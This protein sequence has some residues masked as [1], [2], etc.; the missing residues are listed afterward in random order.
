MNYI[1]PLYP[2][3][4]GCIILMFTTSFA[5]I[6]VISGSIQLVLFGTIVLYPIW[7]TETLSYVDI[8]WPWGL[9]CIGLV[10]LFLGEGYSWRV[11][12]IG[13]LYILM[14]LRMGIGAIQFWL[15]GYI[16][17]EL[18]RYRYQRIRWERKGKTNIQAA[19]Q[20]DALVQGL[21]NV[22]YL[23]LPAFI[24]ASNP[25]PNISVFEVVGLLLWVASFILES[26]ADKQKLGFLRRMKTEKLQNKV[27]EIGL[28]KYTR[29]P[30]YF[31]E[32][33]IWNSL[34]IISIPSWLALQSSESL[35]IWVLLGLAL[36]FV[37]IMMYN[38]LVYLTGAIPSEYYSLQ[39][40][41]N[42]K[43]YTKRVNMFFP[44]F[45]NRK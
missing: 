16:Q 13:A 21:A 3:I 24:I 44:G 19:M 22:S 18:P 7:K 31:A 36:L 42:Y 5:E 25:N 41:P 38:T 28:W 39:K 15:K 26:I 20:I 6:S 1:K 29:H 40:R 32:W 17:K 45:R 33:T 27:C 43:S 14:G 23:A 4:I 10:T 34:I 11:W 37:S 8:G 9:V 2:Y 12:G 30:N 35:I